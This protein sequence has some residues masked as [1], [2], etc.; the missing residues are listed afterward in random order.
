MI[1]VGPNVGAPS[2]GRMLG[3]FGDLHPAESDAF[4]RTI[5]GRERALTRNCLWAELHYMP[6]R[7]RSANVAIRPSVREYE[8]VVDATPGV[9][10]ERVISVCDLVV[11]VRGGRFYLRWPANNVEVR[12]CANHMLNHS[13]APDVCQFLSEVGLDGVAQLSPFDWG[14]AAS[15]PG[16]PRVQFGRSVLR[17][18]EWRLNRISLG[19]FG[20]S[21]PSSRLQQLLAGWRRKWGVP[22]YVYL[23]AGDNRLLL[24]LDNPYHRAELCG[25]VTRLQEG[26]SLTLAE[27]YP[28]PEDCWVAGSGGKYFSE[29]VVSMALPVET[30][31]AERAP[32]GYVAPAR[33][34]FEPSAVAWTERFLVPGDG[35]VF[36]KLYTERDLE[37]HFVATVLRPFASDVLADGAA[38]DWFFIRYADPSP[39]LRLRFSGNSDR[40]VSDCLPR[41]A[42]W[43]AELV[44]NSV[45]DRYVVDTYE[46][47]IERYGGL[48]GVLCAERLFAADSLFVAELVGMDLRGDF[49][50]D[51]VTVNVLTMDAMLTAL[52]LGVDAKVAW[53][54]DHVPQG[55]GRGPEFS[56]RNEP[57][58]RLLSNCSSSCK[59]AADE[60]FRR[61]LNCFVSAVSGVAADLRS[62]EKSS[63]LAQSSGALFASYLHMH[64]NRLMGV[65]RE[66]E[67][68]SLGL[69]RRARISLAAAPL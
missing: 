61:H 42:R 31:P 60:G 23:T 16:L 63:R 26:N 11:G 46:R 38:G 4:L 52:G 12:V 50:V 69:L 47:E 3:R 51:R 44:K 40:I 30:N 39:H 6:R 35:W 56:K 29:F 48:E 9:P 27:V 33:S 36:L 37:D 49:I 25:A 59:P 62:A 19:S 8:I 45:I 13:T 14:P 28:G 64:T 54:R 15:L 53:L 55:F 57:L 17:T 65:D 24:D 21:V 34:V 43:A 58:R 2:A 68:L 18:A 32:A 10:H 22:R 7:F 41:C 1:V 20:A 67:E 5:D 66:S